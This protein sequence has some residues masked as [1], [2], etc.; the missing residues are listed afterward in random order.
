MDLK[1]TRKEGINEHGEKWVE[2]RFKEEDK[3]G[4][5]NET[6]KENE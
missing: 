6:V 3:E 2:E 5:Y 1:K 4:W